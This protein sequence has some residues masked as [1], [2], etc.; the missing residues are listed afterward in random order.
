MAEWKCPDCGNTINFTHRGCRPVNLKH[1]IE[2]IQSELK[3]DWTLE[4]LNDGGEY[5]ASIMAKNAQCISS[6]SG[7]TIEDALF[8]L[9]EEL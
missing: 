2:S 1:I 8:A 3:K 6:A 4:I 9:N 7:E 5:V